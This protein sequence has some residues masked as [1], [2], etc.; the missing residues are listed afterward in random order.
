[1]PG[2]EVGGMT[3]DDWARIKELAQTDVV[4]RLIALARRWFVSVSEDG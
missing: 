1:M 3:L 4:D 2:Q